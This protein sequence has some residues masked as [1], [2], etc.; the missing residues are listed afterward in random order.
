MTV[1]DCFGIGAGAKAMAEAF[2][3][4][5]QLAVVVDLA[6]QDDPALA[7]LVRQGLMAGLEI[8]DREPAEPESEGAVQV[9]AVVVGAAMADARRHR[10][11]PRTVG[12]DAASILVDAA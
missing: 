9:D 1:G 12:R 7:V 5:A 3:L 4:L 8:D 2:E 11:E 6:V 10:F